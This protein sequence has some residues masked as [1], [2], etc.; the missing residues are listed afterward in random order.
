MNFF[1]WVNIFFSGTQK[2]RKAVVQAVIKA[3]RIFKKGEPSKE[4][5][6]ATKLLTSDRVQLIGVVPHV[7]Y[8]RVESKCEEDLEVIWN[9]RFSVP[10][11]LFRIKDSPFLLLAN[12]NIEYNDSKLLEIPENADL[13]ELHDILGIIG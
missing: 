2:Q 10:T 12:P 7:E 13:K 5:D 8:I 1:K 4:G 9:H 6:E 11:L 3:I